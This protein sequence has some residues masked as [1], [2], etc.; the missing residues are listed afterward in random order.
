M[1]CEILCN[2]LIP[3]G[4][5][6]GK[7]KNLASSKQ[8]LFI[9]TM[10]RLREHEYERLESSKY[11]RP[12]HAHYLSCI[13]HKMM[14]KNKTSHVKK[15]ASFLM[16]LIQCALLKITRCQMILI[17]CIFNRVK[18]DAEFCWYRTKMTNMFRNWSIT[19]FVS[20]TS[21]S[22]QT[23]A[24]ILDKMAKAKCPMRFIKL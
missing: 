9:K 23:P 7:T 3:I 20:P 10:A 19:W 14:R 21:S 1:R 22:W 5:D 16:K 17:F 4:L 6:D 18:T 11:K 15:T 8:P 24:S 13:Y 2:V 12:I